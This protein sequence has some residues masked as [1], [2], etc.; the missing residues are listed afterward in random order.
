MNL[1]LAMF[2]LALSESSLKATPAASFSISARKRLL[3]DKNFRASG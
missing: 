2:R 3:G 1:S